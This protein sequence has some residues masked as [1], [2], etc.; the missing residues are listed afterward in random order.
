MI[1]LKLCLI[2]TFKDPNLVKSLTNLVKNLTNLA[3][4]LLKISFFLFCPALWSRKKLFVPLLRLFL[5][6]GMMPLERCVAT[7]YDCIALLSNEAWN[8]FLLSI[9]AGP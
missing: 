8:Q 2:C 4:N 3:E 5:M 9:V 1:F 6:L 7:E